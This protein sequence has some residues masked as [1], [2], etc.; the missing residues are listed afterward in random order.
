MTEQYGDPGTEAPDIKEVEAAPEDAEIE[1]PE[2]EDE[3]PEAVEPRQ[4]DPDTVE[5]A[6]RYGW[7]PPEEWVGS[8]KGYVDD[9]ERFLELPSTLRKRLEESDDRLKKADDRLSRM[10]RVMNT[11]MERQKAQHEAEL[12]SVRKQMRSAVEEGDVEKYDELSKRQEQLS[13]QAPEPEKQD[14][15]PQLP[16]AVSAYMERDEGKWLKDPYLAQQ[17]SMIVDA[18]L[19]ANEV[20]T[21][22]AE[23]QL[24]YAEQRVRQLFP[25]YF[26]TPATRAA[27]TD[28]GGMASARN[29]KPEDK[30]PAEDRATLKGL[31][32]QGIFK[33][34]KE[35]A[36]YYL[37]DN[38]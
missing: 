12:E 31:V 23:A 13:K 27:K 38:G 36:K 1:A 2:A 17:A 10:D 24:R 33:D 25:Q 35:A 37:E 7:K 11:A 3:A 29:S 9:P 5:K 26:E 8:K 30:I 14:D 4:F 22:N 19:K 6:R 20:P 21:G 32:D 15:K 28:G 18:G 16:P 34:M